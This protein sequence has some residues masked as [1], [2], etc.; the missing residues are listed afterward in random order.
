MD[1]ISVGDI[2]QLH[3]NTTLDTGLVAIARL[4]VVTPPRSLNLG[5]LGQSWT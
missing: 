2:V 4:E 5:A 3:D 1:I